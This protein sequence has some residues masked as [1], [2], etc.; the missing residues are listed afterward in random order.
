MANAENIAKANERRTPSERRENARKAGKASGKARK[1][2]ADLRKAVQDALNGTYTV[3]TKTGEEKMTGSEM[4]VASLLQI[5]GNPKN[6][7]S[8]VSAFNTL[9]KM[10]GQDSAIVG[11]TEDDGFIEALKGTIAEDWDDV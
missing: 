3:K 4:V 11:E 2:K 5:A 7:G 8:A 9:A 1:E 6:R 10:M